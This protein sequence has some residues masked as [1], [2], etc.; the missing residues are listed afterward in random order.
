[1]VYQFQSICQH[2]VSYL[3]MQISM[4]NSM[5]LWLT[6]M[7]QLAPLEAPMPWSILSVGR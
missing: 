5:V 4:Y 1:M 7:L 6:D 3:T 2:H